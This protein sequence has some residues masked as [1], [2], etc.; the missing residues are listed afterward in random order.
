MLLGTMHYAPL[1]LLFVVNAF[2]TIA[3]VEILIIA[4]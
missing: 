4:V 2:L 3:I 1:M